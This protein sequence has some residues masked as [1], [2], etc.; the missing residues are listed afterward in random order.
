MYQTYQTV[1]KNFYWPYQRI[2]VEQFVAS[3]SICAGKANYVKRP[4]IF[5]K[6]II[7]KPN[8]GVQ[9]DFVGPLPENVYNGKHVKYIVT[10]VDTYSRYLVAVPTEG[11]TSKDALHALLNNWVA[12]FGIPYRI[13]SDRGSHFTSYLF[14]NACKQLGILKTSTIGSNP[15]GNAKV[16]RVH[17]SV[18]LTLRGLDGTD[19]AKYLPSKVFYY[20]ISVNR[21]TKFSPFELFFGRLPGIPLDLLLP[22]RGALALSG[23]ERLRNIESECRARSEKE[24]KSETKIRFKFQGFKQKYK[25]GDKVWYYKPTAGKLRR[26]WER[27]F[28]VTQI[29]NDTVVEIS[30]GNDK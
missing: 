18:K 12:I 20:N 10:M 22:D 6:E 30:D 26:D 21:I 16:E 8:Y 27:P 15:T 17:G 29:I 14:K 13:H 25:P 3:C 24:I 11:A 5:F 19:W 1:K 9:I 23:F 7:G 4:K 28:K 2:H